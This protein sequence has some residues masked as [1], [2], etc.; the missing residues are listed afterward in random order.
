MAGGAVAYHP[1]DH[2][3]AHRASAARRGP[4]AVQV[5]PVISPLTTLLPHA[6]V[7]G[8]GGRSR[9]GRGAT[10]LA[11]ALAAGA[12]Q[13]G[14]WVAAVG[15]PW[16]G[17]GA[18]AECGIVLDR[19]AVVPAPERSEWATVVAAL[20]D[21]IDVGA[22]VP[23]AASG[24][25]ATPAGSPPAARQ[26][27]A[28]CCV[29]GAT[30]SLT[31]DVRCTVSDAKWSGVEHGAGH[32]SSRGESRSPHPGGGARRAPRTAS[33]WPPGPDGVIATCAEVAS[34][35]AARAGRGGIGRSGAH[36]LC[37]AVPSGR[38]WPR[39]QCPTS[40]SRLRTPT[41]LIA[42]SPAAGSRER[43]RAASP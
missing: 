39:A 42:S 31:V 24:D 10:S 36:A 21:V 40:R 13:E 11:S 28:R 8:R 38:S 37:C 1:G 16:L 41:A 2:S 23:A 25:G 17:L 19:L 32:L 5:L 43:A 7:R 18:A 9:R 30:S 27:V 15:V 29:V 20:V 33:L 14:S 35:D 22:R 12:S 4:L 34:G 6:L 26:R 3:R